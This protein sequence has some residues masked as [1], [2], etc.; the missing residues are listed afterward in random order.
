M[1]TFIK[2]YSLS[3][4]RKKFILLYCL[5]VLDITFTLLLLQTG[6]FQEVNF[7]MM[8]V[9]QNPLIS[10]LIK[11]I[12]PAI[13]LYYMYH[14][15]K[16]AD[17]SQLKVSNIAVNISLMIYVVVNLTHLIWVALLPFVILYN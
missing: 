5:N 4:I 9:V 8:K 15:I 13:L 7:F 10:L 16:D 12:F 2:N 3:T 1:V 6:Y 14:Q 17:I 11:V